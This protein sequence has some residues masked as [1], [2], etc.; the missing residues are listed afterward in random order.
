MIYASRMIRNG[1]YIIFAYA[2]ISY[3]VIMLLISFFQI[4]TKSVRKEKM[5]YFFQNLLTKRVK[6]DITVSGC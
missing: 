2:K 3:A 1:Y 5:S 4:I 6:C